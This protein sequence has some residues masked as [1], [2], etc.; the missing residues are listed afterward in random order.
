M[1]D[2]SV[3]TSNFNTKL[4]SMNGKLGKLR[5]EIHET[6][7]LL[8]RLDAMR[9]T[10]GGVSDHHVE[11][12][13][14]EEPTQDDPPES[15]SLENLRESN[16]PGYS[17]VYTMEVGGQDI[18]VI[19]G[20]VTTWQSSSSSRGSI[21]FSMERPFKKEIFT[22]LLMTVYESKETI[23]TEY[24]EIEQIDIQGADPKDEKAY[25][26]I[27]IDNSDPEDL[28]EISEGILRNLQFRAGKDHTLSEFDDLNLFD[29]PD[30]DD[31]DINPLADLFSEEEAEDDEDNHVS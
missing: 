9:K 30:I 18:E 13:P 26:E 14:E 22:D 11:Q 31:A 7:N 3:N 4:D 10:D 12:E 25:L 2:I 19:V 1:Y 17:S 27:A 29:E 15:L 28:N 6:N 8:N 24:G 5:D 21:T 16:S 23:A 20:E